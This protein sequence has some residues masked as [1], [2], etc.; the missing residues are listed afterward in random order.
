[1]RALLILTVVLATGCGSTLPDTPPPK[2]PEPAPPPPEQPFEP[3]LPTLPA[4]EAPPAPDA[5]APPDLATPPAEAAATESGLHWKVLQRGT[6]KEHPRPEDTVT[7]HYT[8]WMTNGVKFDSSLD[9]GQPATYGVDKVMAGWTEGLQMMVTGEKRR[10]W[11]PGSL[12]FGDKP[13]PYGRPWGTLV[14][15]IQL[16]TIKR[17]PAPPQTPPDLKTPPPD[18]HRTRSG[19]VYRVLEKGSGREHPR[20]QSTVEVNYS[21]WTADGTMFDS[22]VVRGEPA[23]FPLN[24]VIRG[25]TE[26]VQLMVVGDK[27]RF[28]IPAALAYGDHPAA[29]TPAGPLV[30]DIELVAIKDPAPGE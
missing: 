11:I 3:L 6:G 14:Y 22:S 4:A 30:F 1:M 25:W 26:G 13:R 16:L 10:F 7:V 29:G 20:R 17:A 5:N 8:G 15:D 9:T 21:G 23:S 12:A 18:A 19:L 2:P 24:H 28:W 27:T